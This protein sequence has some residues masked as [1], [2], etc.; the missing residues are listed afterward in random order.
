MKKRYGSLF[1]VSIISLAI[2]AFSL[3]LSV[4]ILG[5]TAEISLFSAIAAILGILGLI[6]SLR[7][8]K[9]SFGCL[10]TATVVSA[11]FALISLGYSIAYGDIYII[12]LIYFC[13]YA[14]GAAAAYPKSKL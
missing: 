7:K 11:G 9:A 10:I 3:F 1:A 8:G 6:G 5:P 13:L 2:S 4:M 14:A 12:A